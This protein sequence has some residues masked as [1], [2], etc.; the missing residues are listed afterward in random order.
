MTEY[1]IAK[2]IRLSRDDAESGSLSIPHQHMILDRFIEE[3]DIKNTKVLEFVDN[4]YTGTNYERPAF[5]EMLELIQSGGLHCIICRDF[6][7]LGRNIIETGY[8]FEQ[9][10]PLYGIRFIAVSKGYD[11]DKYKGD[12]GGIDVAFEFLINEYYSKDLSKKVRS[13]LTARRKAGKYIGS[14]PY[15]YYK[16]ENRRFEIDEKAADVIRFIFNMALSGNKP[17]IIHKALFNEKYPTPAEHFAIMKGLEITPSYIWRPAAIR[18][19][20]NNEQYIG[21]YI[22]GKTIRTID[23]N[24]KTIFVDESEWIRIPDHHPT[25]IS[26]EDFIEVQKKFGK[27]KATHVSK[28]R[29]NLLS[30]KVFCGHCRKAMKYDKQYRDIHYYKCRRTEPNPSAACYRLKVFEYD[31]DGTIMNV[32][33][34]LAEVAMNIYDLSNLQA[35]S[36]DTNDQNIEN[37]NSQIKQCIELRQKGYEQF[38]LKEIDNIAFQSIKDECSDQ[39][40]RLENQIAISKQSNRDAQEKQKITAIANDVLSESVT[41]HEIVNKLIDKILVFPGNHIEIIWKITDFAINE[42]VKVTL[43]ADCSSSHK[44]ELSTR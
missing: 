10:F 22:S 36:T 15:G 27:K 34:K 19:I 29:G 35:V 14:P 12:T 16:G 13:A 31:L 6:S 3:M 5:Q 40:R 24:R 39:I 17:S 4:G 20:L 43:G 28:S 2:Y 25:I 7:R 21:T 26:T 30:G 37:L 41:Q 44:V 8:L 11:S 42:G 23:N 18:E 33:K 1:I 32:I 9:V 38:I